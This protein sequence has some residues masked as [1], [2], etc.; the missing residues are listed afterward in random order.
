M[1]DVEV[2]QQAFNKIAADKMMAEIRE[3][4]IHTAPV[5]VQNIYGEYTRLMEEKNSEDISI[6]EQ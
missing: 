2:L 3:W 6:D 4:F 1:I 5:D